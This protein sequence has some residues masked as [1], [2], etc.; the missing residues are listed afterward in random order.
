[1]LNKLSQEIHKDNLV[2]GFWEDQ[3]KILKTFSGQEELTSSVLKTFNAQRIA[4]MHSEL[5]EAVEADR[6]NL[7]DDKL[8]EYKGLDVELADCLI[9]ILDFC[10]YH[11]IDLDTIVSKKLEYN[12][13]R[14]YKH[15]KS[16]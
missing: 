9:R 1:M 8:S 11:K 4:L 16:Y 12:R 10:G 6:K 14:E 5:S 13:S 3:E 7:M 2:K 15:G